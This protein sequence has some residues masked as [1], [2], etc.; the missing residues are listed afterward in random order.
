M[1]RSDCS[2]ILPPSANCGS[3]GFTL[4]EL[5]IVVL[6][7]GIMAA[8]TLP[9]FSRSLVYYRAEAAAERIQVDLELAKKRALT[10]N[11]A[12][13]VSFNVASDRYSLPGVENL[14][15][16]GTVYEV[17]LSGHPYTAQLVSAA[18]D[19]AADA[20]VEFNAYGVPDSAGTVVIRVGSEQRTVVVDPNSSV[21]EIQ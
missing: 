7:I 6:I 20:D 19:D 12:Q 18:F 17:D 5:I 1:M 11:T 2:T 13:V 21:T 15:H 8:V 16:P 4:I 14:D 3:R 9:T 10:S